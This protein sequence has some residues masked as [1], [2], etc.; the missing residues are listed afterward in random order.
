MTCRIMLLVPVVVAMAAQASAQE[1]E[2]RT[3][4]GLVSEEV[5]REKLKHYGVTGVQ[6]LLEIGGVY[7]IR[8][9]HDGRPVRLQMNE[10]TGVLRESGQLLSLT[11]ARD[12]FQFMPRVDPGA[13]SRLDQVLRFEMRSTLDTTVSTHEHVHPEPQAPR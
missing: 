11:P 13:A 5:A 3:R 1:P 7:E 6:S 12:A 8:A 10:R 9:T 2:F 4:G